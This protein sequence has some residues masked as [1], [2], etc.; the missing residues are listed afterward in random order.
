[1][2]TLELDSTQFVTIAEGREHW[3]AAAFD[4][5][6]D[7]ASTYNEVIA[8]GQLAQEVQR[9]AGLPTK[10]AHRTWLDGVLADVTRRCHAEGLPQLA[11]LVVDKTSG[12]VTGAYD[13]VLRVSGEPAI[14]DDLTREQ[15]AARTRLACYQRS[16]ASMPKN[17]R[18]TLSP[19][20]VRIQERKRVA[21]HAAKAELSCPRCH[22]LLSPAGVCVGCL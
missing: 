19:T 12:Q 15:H 6:E 9:R 20:F 17:A 22:L 3:A 21:A 8:P 14:T 4:A 2:N 10:A 13:E 1:M 11:A 5:L 18:A 7:V 16:C